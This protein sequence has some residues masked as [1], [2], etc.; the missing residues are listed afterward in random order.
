[1]IQASLVAQQRVQTCP[2]EVPRSRVRPLLRPGKPQPKQ[3]AYTKW[4]A[5]FGFFCACTCA[6]RTKAHRNDGIFV[7]LITCA[8]KSNAVLR[9]LDYREQCTARLTHLASFSTDKSF[10]KESRPVRRQ[11]RG[12]DLSAARLRYTPPSS[13]STPC[14]A[15]SSRLRIA[16]VATAQGLL[17][18]LHQPS[19]RDSLQPL[20]CCLDHGSTPPSISLPAPPTRRTHRCRRRQRS[21]YDYLRVRVF[22]TRAR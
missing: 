19:R 16:S 21:S 2:G 13:P 20:P 4:G 17:G 8:R 18:P 10:A 6:L 7:P 11:F 1:M 22:F 9:L 3:R 14:F 5:V 12:A 15:G